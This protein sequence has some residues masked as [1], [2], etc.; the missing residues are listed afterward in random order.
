MGR[1][2]RRFTLIEFLVVIAIIAI[3]A[4]MLLPALNR[5]KTQAKTAAC[6]GNI[7]QLGMGVLGY[8]M[9]YDDIVLPYVG[10]FNEGS[11]R[12]IGGPGDEYKYW[13]YYVRSYVGIKIDNPDI[14]TYYPAN[15]PAQYQKGIL[16]CPA[17]DCGIIRSLGYVCYGIPQY[18]I[19]GRFA[20]GTTTTGLKYQKIKSP[21]NV[22]Y[23]LDSVYY[24]KGAG[25]LIT[26]MDNSLSS[27]V[28]FYVVYNTG[29]QI[30]RKRHGGRTNAF[31]PDGHTETLM[32]SFMK[33]ELS[34]SLWYDSWLLGNKAFK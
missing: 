3:L 2:V 15:V 14:S 7:K 31:F 6:I 29:N 23:L 12:S 10:Y 25:S 4:G 11:F 5:A 33:Q 30:S 16:K 9:D 32:E 28:G 21:S 8:G 20:Y 1:N 22:A 27:N 18:F 24:E 19:G 13:I 17:A 34:G 26:G